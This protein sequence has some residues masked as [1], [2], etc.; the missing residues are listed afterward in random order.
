MIPFGW[1][2]LILL[3]IALVIYIVEKVVDPDWE[4]G[5]AIIS[6]LFL[7][8]I[9]I[10]F[11]GSLFTKVPSYY[12][13]NK[14]EESTI[15]S[16]KTENN[17]SGS[18]FLGSGYIG[19]NKNYYYYTLTEDGYSLKHIPV[20]G[21]FVKEITDNKH[22]YILVSKADNNLTIFGGKFLFGKIIKPVSWSY[23][24]ILKQQIFLP[25]DYIIFEYSIQ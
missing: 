6:P 25:S 10:L 7:I 3:V 1:G 23:E 24:E 21:T 9:F 15:Y 16:L 8:L 11:L 20:E 4:E 13:N 12:T 17:I 19:E 22:P 14:V 2:V 5:T 18:F